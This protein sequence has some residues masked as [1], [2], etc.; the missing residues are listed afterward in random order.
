MEQR[1]DQE[2]WAHVFAS[3]RRLPFD[4]YS[5]VYDP[6]PVPGEPPVIGSLLDD[7]ADIYG[8][9]VS[10]LRTYHA[11]QQNSA[12]WGWTFLMQA[13]W[14]QHATSSIRALHCWLAKNEPSKLSAEIR[15]SE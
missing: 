13:H 1:V 12:A 2:E 14:G 15:S 3:L 5:E 6:L 10:G 9:V 7:L 4:F 11:G 8:D